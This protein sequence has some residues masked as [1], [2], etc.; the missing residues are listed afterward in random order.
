MKNKMTLHNSNTAQRMLAFLLMLVTSTLLM[1]G[2]ANGE[3][4]SFIPAGTTVTAGGSGS[5]VTAS[6]G[7][8]VGTNVIVTAYGNINPQNPSEWG[9]G[10]TVVFKSP[11][12]ASTLEALARAKGVFDPNNNWHM[13]FSDTGSRSLAAGA[14]L[15]AID[16]DPAT[17]SVVYRKRI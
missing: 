12:L 5:N 10:V 6:V 15:A 13:F 11:P 16:S 3:K 17:A 9:T 8:P 14:A 2:C 4:P 1:C 7:I